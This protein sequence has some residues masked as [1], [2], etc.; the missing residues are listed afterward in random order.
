MNFNIAIFNSIH[1]C[2]KD[3]CKILAN[4]REQLNIQYKPICPILIHTNEHKKCLISSSM[5]ALHC[6]TQLLTYT[7]KISNFPQT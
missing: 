7:L 2:S 3:W 4:E 1:Y 6:A 5:V